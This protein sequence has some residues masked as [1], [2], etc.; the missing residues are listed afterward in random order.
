[1][2]QLFCTLTNL[3]EVIPHCG[4]VIGNYPL[5]IN[6]FLKSD[7]PVDPENPTDKEMAVENNTT[8]NVYMATEFLSGF[9]Q[10]RYNVMLN[11]LH[12]TLHMGHDKSTNTITA[13][14]NLFLNW[15]GDVKGPNV[16]L[17]D[18]VTFATEYEEADAHATNG[19]KITRAGKPVI[20]HIC[21]NNKYTNKCPYGE[22]SASEK[23]YEKY[24]DNSDKEASSKKYSVNVTIMEY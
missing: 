4:G 1:M 17:N 6:K 13:A 19:M 24:E 14:Y 3:R 10:G 5:L 23:K 15:K 2:W 22:E 18:G 11:E 9:I 12:N 8:E 20:G 7:K 21:G 16:A